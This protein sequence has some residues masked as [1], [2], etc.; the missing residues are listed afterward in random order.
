[1]APALA[2]RVESTVYAARWGGRARGRRAQSRW[3][4]GASSRRRARARLAASAAART[5]QHRPTASLH[6][7]PL[8]AALRTPPSPLSPP[9]VVAPALPSSRALASGGRPC[10]FRAAPTP[11]AGH[12]RR[13]ASSPV[14]CLAHSAR[15]TGRGRARAPRQAPHV[16][17]AHARYPRRCVRAPQRPSS[18]APPP[19]DGR[20]PSCR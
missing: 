12:V 3:R 15:S 8:R 14:R 2:P 6:E 9:A 1:M 13:A 18:A 4:I 19:P 16:S 5:A 11:T 20:W 17:A 7:R 10:G